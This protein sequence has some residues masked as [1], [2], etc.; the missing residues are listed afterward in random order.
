MSF[1]SLLWSV[2]RGLRSKLPLWIEPDDLVQEGRIALWRAE[3]QLQRL[4]HED[5]QV[6]GGGKHALAYAAQVARW[7]MLD[8]ARRVSGTT[9]N[10]RENNLC[11]ATP[12]DNE[13]QAAQDVGYSPSADAQLQGR[14]FIEHVI[15]GITKLEKHPK[16]VPGQHRLV[17]TLLIDGCS[18][19]QIAKQLN[20]DPA[21][22]SQMR[23]QFRK[24]VM[25]YV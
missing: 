16:A 15:A 8:Y 4:Q 2:A 11:H 10:V 18:P 20:I 19:N 22:I 7:R 5:A 12:L 6:P 1:E 21:R 9:K 14:Q 23:T 17:I 13:Q 24:I 3:G 25:E